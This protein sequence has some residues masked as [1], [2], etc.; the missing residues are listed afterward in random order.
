MLTIRPAEPRDTDAIWKIL[1]PL[2]HAGE[3][4]T[5]PR[6]LHREDGLK[7]WLS[8]AHEVFVAEEEGAV[9]GS[10]YLRANRHG[11]GSHVANSGYMTAKTATG[12]GIARRMCEHSLDQARSRGFR[13]MQFNFVISTNQHAVRLWQSCGFAIVGTLPKAFLHP[14]AGYVDAFVMYREL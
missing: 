13:A 12:R 10:Y 9:L 4:F 14:Q 8:D 6:S 1:E 3:V 11:G 5:L 7:Y 2:V